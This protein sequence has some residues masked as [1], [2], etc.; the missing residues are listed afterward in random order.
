MIFLRVLL[1]IKFCP[2]N[3]VQIYMYVCERIFLICQYM[4]KLGE[5][6]K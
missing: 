1:N 5:N 6:I 3:N 4:L 2:D